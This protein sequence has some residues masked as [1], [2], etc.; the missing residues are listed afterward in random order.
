MYSDTP[1]YKYNGL[2]GLSQWKDTIKF[3]EPG[4]RFLKDKVYTTYPKGTSGYIE[5]WNKEKEKVLNGVS[6]DGQFISGYEYFYLNYCPIPLQGSKSQIDFADFWDLDA[7]WFKQI[8]S[9]ETLKKYLAALKARRRG[10][11]L[12]DMIPITRK[13]VFERNTMSYLAAYLD[14]HANKSMA[15]VKRYLNH[16]NKNTGWFRSRNPNTNDHIKIAYLDNKGIEKGRLNELYKILL[17]DNPTKGV[18]GNCL[19]ENSLIYNSDNKLVKVQDIKVGDYILGTDNKPKKV[20]NVKHGVDQL[21]RIKQIRKNDYIVTEDHLLYLKNQN[22]NKY[23][24][25]S[26]K[27]F[28]NLKPWAQ[29]QLRGVYHTGLEYQEKDISIDPYWLGLWLGDGNR[30]APTILVNETKDFEIQNYIIRYAEKLGYKCKIYNRN[31]KRPGYKDL[32]NDVSINNNGRWSKNLLKELKLYNLYKNKHI[33]K[34]FLENTREI[35][36]KVLAGILDT[37]GYLSEKNTF[38]ISIADDKLCN[39]LKTLCTSLGLHIQHSLSVNSGKTSTVYNK[40]TITNRLQIKGNITEIPTLLPRKQAKSNGKNDPY[41]GIIQIEYY[42]KDKYAGFEC[43]D[44]LFILE[45]GTITHNCDLFVYEEAGIVPGTQLLDTLEYVKAATEDGDIV[46]GLI[47]IYGSVGEL[48]KCQSLKS[49]FLNPK[50]NGFMEFDNIWGDETIGNNKCGYFVPEYI[51]MKPFIDKDGNSQID[52]ALD[53]ISKKRQEKKKLSTKQYIIYVTQH[54]IKPSEA[55]LGRARSPFPIDRLSQHLMRL[56][57]SGEYKYGYA[58]KLHN[59]K[60]V[61]KQQID[62]TIKSPF[63]EYPVDISKQEGSEGTVWIYEPPISQNKVQNLYY[64]ATDSVDQNVAP[65]SDSLFCTY[66]Y[67]KDPGELKLYDDNS[68]EIHK[69]K[70]EIV[71]SYIGRR[72]K[73][74][75]CYDISMYLSMLYGCKNLV[76]NVNIGIINHHINLNRDYLLQDQLDEIKGINPGSVVKRSKGFHPTKEVISHGDDLV[77]SYCLQVIGYEYKTNEKGEQEIQREILG[78]ERIRDLGLLREMIEYDGEINVDRLTTFRAC[79]LYKEATEKKQVKVLSNKND[80]IAQAAKFAES[81][82]A[83]NRHNKV[84]DNYNKEKNKTVFKYHP[85]T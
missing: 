38:E 42:G 36:L 56:E 25:I 83:K 29:K 6:I 33:P 41:S 26:V 78:L 21:F 77:N 82:L 70:D 14:A 46:N 39:D 20:L 69:F 75:E 63:S 67:K 17:K 44:S 51:C 49:I 27:D 57:S 71:A 53:R 76:E 80:P 74:E 18:G 32:M 10:F 50:T 9:A 61:I 23:L 43:E 60:G 35:R 34:D 30:N 24:N 65:T 5:Y 40:E 66:I 37:D 19:I 81:M 3:K 4:L 11:S 52:E 54:P 47:I 59:D 12:K 16:I 72:D 1:F 2:D 85:K 8:D 68:I 15:F 45:D 48:E 28:M 58:V 31:I 62:Y 22:T 84:W 73:V 64:Q 13:L 79:L 55:F 7:D